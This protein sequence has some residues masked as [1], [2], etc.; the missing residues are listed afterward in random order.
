MRA[1]SRNAEDARE[2]LVG[3]RLVLIGAV[4]YLLEWVAIIAAQVSVPLGADASR[5][6][7]VDS[8][9]GRADA[10]G[11]A[12]G[13]FSVVLLGR[14][15]IMVGL[16]TS[17]R[18]SGRP[19]PLMD[20][21]VA[22]MAVSVA[23]EIATYAIPSGAAWALG[24]GSGLAVTRGLDSVSFTLNQMLWGPIGVSVLCAGIAMWQARLFP[25][26]LWALALLSGV[27]GAVVAAV[28]SSPSWY[29]VADAGTSVTAL[30]FW[31]WMLWSGVLL[32][33]RTPSRAARAPETSAEQ[34]S[35]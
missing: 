28:A 16:R 32:V 23:L 6:S 12:A 13:W 8:Y 35:G 1:S 3:N 31:I 34:L 4:M 30:A 14:I 11:W 27:S 22:A 17:L 15:L 25:W 18:D 20:L 19:Q 2:P 33:I 26:P 7:L 9:A 5:H 10:L 24:H 21:A 29:G